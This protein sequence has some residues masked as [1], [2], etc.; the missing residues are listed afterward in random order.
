[1]S[2]E[3]KDNAGVNET[4]N[5]AECDAK[6]RDLLNMPHHQSSTRPHMSMHDRAAQF[7][8]FDAL[9]GYDDAIEQ[10]ARENEERARNEYR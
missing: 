2:D 8:P 9:T 5:A 10:T 7:A 4:D 1:V 3:Y 6:Y